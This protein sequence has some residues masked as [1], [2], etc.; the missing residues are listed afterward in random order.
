[1][2]CCA[3]VQRGRFD[4]VEVVECS[5]VRVTPRGAESCWNVDGELLPDNRVTARVHHGLVE[6]F[7]RGV[8]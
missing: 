5:A 2:G 8:E 1:M 4:F 3:G 6:V 7:A